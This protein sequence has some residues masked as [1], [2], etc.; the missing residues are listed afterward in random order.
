MINNPIRTI[1][2]TAAG[3]A[4]LTSVLGLGAL[5]AASMANAAPVSNV[6]QAPYCQVYDANGNPAY[7]YWGYCR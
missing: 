5:G 2:R 4:L 7:W 1:V 6:P 3:T